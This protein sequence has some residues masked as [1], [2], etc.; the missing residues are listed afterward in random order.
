[1]L[2]PKWHIKNILFDQQSK[3]RY[4]MLQFYLKII[5][6]NQVVVILLEELS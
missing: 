2:C 3:T 5:M 6:S 4:M 1:M